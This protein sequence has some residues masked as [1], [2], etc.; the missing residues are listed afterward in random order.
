MCWNQKLPDCSVLVAGT[1][2]FLPPRMNISRKVGL[3]EELELQP[4][5]SDTR[6][7]PPRCQG[8]LLCQTSSCYFMWRITG[9]LLWSPRAI[10]GCAPFNPVSFLK[11]ESHERRIFRS[12]SSSAP[13]TQ[14]Q[15]LWCDA[16]V[17]SSVFTSWPNVHLGI[18][19]NVL[20]GQIG[21]MYIFFVR[22]CFHIK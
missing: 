21:V 5:F 6:F 19:L 12:H 3:E 18:I 7:R 16:F 1:D 20:C 10:P 15:A 2:R 22:H 4:C 17:P 9:I 13:G 14:T 11:W 8:Q